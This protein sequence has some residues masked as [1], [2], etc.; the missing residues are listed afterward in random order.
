MSGV[1]STAM[2]RGV[3]ITS[4]GSP[5]RSL[6]ASGVSR[7]ASAAA[8]RTTS[9]WAASSGERATASAA[10]AVSAQPAHTASAARTVW[11]PGGDQRMRARRYQRCRRDASGLRRPRGMGAWVRS[12]SAWPSHATA[13]MGGRGIGD[14]A[15]G[16]FGVKGPRSL[17]REPRKSRLVVDGEALAPAGTSH[18]SRPSGND[19]SPRAPLSA[20][21]V[22]PGRPRPRRAGPRPRGARGPACRPR[23]P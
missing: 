6:V 16:P 5:G 22:G 23:G 20:A 12:R 19:P 13:S 3:S 11:R 1:T 7:A 15:P 17:R 4:W 10:T 14:P 21:G 2:S 8:S 18:G 9:G